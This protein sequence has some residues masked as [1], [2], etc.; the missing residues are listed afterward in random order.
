M[1]YNLIQLNGSELCNDKEIYFKVYILITPDTLQ[2]LKRY[3]HYRQTLIWN[4]FT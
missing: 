3:Q 4:M 2:S 1:T